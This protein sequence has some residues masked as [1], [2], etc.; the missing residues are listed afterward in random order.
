VPYPL[1]PRTCS[2]I[3][4][5]PIGARVRM[6]RRV[7]YRASAARSRPSSRGEQRFPAFHVCGL[8]GH[9]SDSDPTKRTRP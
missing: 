9:A 6:A 2:A 4:G 8:R 3:D 7:R 5:C 1:N